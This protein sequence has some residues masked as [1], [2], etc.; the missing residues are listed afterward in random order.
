MNLLSIIRGK[1][2]QP[3]PEKS[4]KE[5]IYHPDDP[6]YKSFLFCNPAARGFLT[7]YPDGRQERRVIV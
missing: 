7:T 1:K 4:K 6:T 5:I 2:A 3:A